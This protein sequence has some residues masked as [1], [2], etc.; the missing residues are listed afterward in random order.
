MSRLWVDNLRRY[1]GLK[2]TAVER[3]SE[4]PLGIPSQTRLIGLPKR[5][6]LWGRRLQFRPTFTHINPVDSAALRLT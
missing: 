3:T 2:R 1:C 5:E 6:R 4:P